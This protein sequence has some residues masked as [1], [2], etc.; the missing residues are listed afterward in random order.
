MCDIVPVRVETLPDVAE[1]NLILPLLESVINR[2]P[3]E[4]NAMPL[5]LLKVTLEAIR[6]SIKGLSSTSAPAKVDTKADALMTRITLFPVSANQIS[7]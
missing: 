5:G 4:S 3:L 2:F 6:L 1:Y 7:K